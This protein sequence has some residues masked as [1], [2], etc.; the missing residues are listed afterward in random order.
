MHSPGYASNAG[1][2]GF[3]GLPFHQGRVDCPCHTVRL[4]LRTPT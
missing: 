2:L 4:S 3:S 1:R